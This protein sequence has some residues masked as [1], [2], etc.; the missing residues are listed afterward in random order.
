AGEGKSTVALQLALHIARN[1]LNKVC[2][3]DLSL[4]DDQLSRLLGLPSQRLGLMNLLEHREQTIP[5]LQV[6]GDDGPVIMLA[7]KA[8]ANP[9]K[10]ARSRREHDDRPIVA[11]H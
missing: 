6:S 9:A 2:L 10:V 1:T 3:I 5:A 7:G 11:T 4:G 8:P